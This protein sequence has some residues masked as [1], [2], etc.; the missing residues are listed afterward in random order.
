MTWDPE[1]VPKPGEKYLV[2]RAL[3]GDA[4]S[5]SV[6]PLVLLCERAGELWRS[7]HRS[8][9][10]QCG[11]AGY[12]HD[13]TVAYCFYNVMAVPYSEEAEAVARLGGVP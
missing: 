9:S 4:Y 13:G 12:A 2:V 6:F 5:P 11:L 3:P 1:Y 8:G 7:L 10:G